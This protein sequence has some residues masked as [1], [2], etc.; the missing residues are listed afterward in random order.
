MSPQRSPEV[1]VIAM[2]LPGSLQ[3]GRWKKQHRGPRDCDEHVPTGGR[4]DADAEMKLGI[5]Q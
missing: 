4:A 2:A 1:I 3:N 5:G